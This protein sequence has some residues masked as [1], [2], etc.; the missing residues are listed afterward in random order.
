MDA[1]CYSILFADRAI[2][3]NNGKKGLIGIFSAFNFP[4]FPAGVPSWFIY[5]ALEMVP[6]WKHEQANL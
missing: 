3:E 6:P 1:Q 4:Q 2:T 5:I